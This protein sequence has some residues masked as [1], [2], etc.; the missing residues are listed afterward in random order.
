M[1]AR[2]SAFTISAVP[3]PTTWT[4]ARGATAAQMNPAGIPQMAVAAAAAA[5]TP[6]ARGQRRKAAGRGGGQDAADRAPGSGSPAASGT[7]VVSVMFLSRRRGS[8]APP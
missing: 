6:A 8:R 4:R 3:V 2:V 5:K 7:C 1:N